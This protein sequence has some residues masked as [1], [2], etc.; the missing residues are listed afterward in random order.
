MSTGKYDFPGIKK[1]G[2]KGLS[3]LLATFSW[4]A[5]ILKWGFGPLVDLLLMSLANY[6]ANQGLVILNIGAIYVEGKF[7]QKAFDT[8]MNE[9]IKAVEEARG[10]LTPEQI[11]AIDDDV[12]KAADKFLPYTRP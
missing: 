8:A 6:L 12:I 1:A 3:M 5:W 11:K 4:G 7:D 10:K 9:G 2:A